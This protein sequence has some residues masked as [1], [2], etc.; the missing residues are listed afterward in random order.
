MMRIKFCVESYDLGTVET[1]WL[2]MAV[3]LG[4][5]HSISFLGKIY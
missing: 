1:I 5:I 2:Q 3:I 4:I